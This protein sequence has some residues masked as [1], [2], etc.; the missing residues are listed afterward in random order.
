VVRNDAISLGDIRVMAPS[1]IVVS[2]GPGTPNDSG[3]SLQVLDELST[4]TPVLGVCLG[5]QAIGQV[6]G[7]VV[8]RAPHLMHGKTS[9]IYHSGEGVFAGLPSP[10]EA[11][12]YH[13]L[14][15]EESTLPASLKVTARTI[16]GDIM[17]LQHRDRPV[18]GVQFHPE[19]ILTQ[20]GRK[21]LNNF[22]LMQP[23][24]AED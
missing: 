11:T 10:F 21:L 4:H 12:R 1:H 8:R 16:E 7:G 6:F 2:P 17:G 19:S 23:V 13:S 5:H 24:P 9:L 15:V 20:D 3:V 18:H 14:I 22:L